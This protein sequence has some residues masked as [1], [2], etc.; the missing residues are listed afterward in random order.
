MFHVKQFV[1]KWNNYNTY[2]TKWDSV[3]KWNT[4]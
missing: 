2:M 1:T 4:K 3:A